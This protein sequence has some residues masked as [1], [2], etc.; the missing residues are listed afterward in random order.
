MSDLNILNGILPDLF[1]RQSSASGIPPQTSYMRVIQAN[2][3]R[4]DVKH[5]R[6]KGKYLSKMKEMTDIL[7]SS[8]LLPPK[9]RDHALT[10]NRLG[11][12]NCQVEP[13]RI[14]IYKTASG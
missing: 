13:D 8:S 2:V 9:N 11:W 6:K 3:F 7:A 1:H 5:L 4:K 14:L 10:G 12:R